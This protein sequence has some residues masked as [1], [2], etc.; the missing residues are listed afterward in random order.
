MQVECTGERSSFPM[1]LYYF[2][3]FLE[4]KLIPCRYRQLDLSL[5]LVTSNS[6]LHGFDKSLIVIWNMHLGLFMFG[7]N[8]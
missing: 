7:G 5:P 1:E 6:T 8:I 2:S 3:A 4:A